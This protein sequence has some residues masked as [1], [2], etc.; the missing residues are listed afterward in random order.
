MSR[1]FFSEGQQAGLSGLYSLIR[2]IVVSGAANA[3]RLAPAVFPDLK[4]ACSDRPRSFWHHHP[5]HP[6]TRSNSNSKSKRYLRWLR[7]RLLDILLMYA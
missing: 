5:R 1:K 4:P 3:R 6:G 7:H 2:D